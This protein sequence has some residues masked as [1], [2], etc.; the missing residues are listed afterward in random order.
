MGASAPLWF[1]HLTARI[2]DL[3]SRNIGS[4]PIGTDVY[5][6]SAFYFIYIGMKTINIAYVKLDSKLEHH[7][8]HA[9]IALSFNKNRKE[10]I[11]SDVCK[12]TI[13]KI[14]W[15]TPQLVSKFFPEYS[16]RISG[17]EELRIESKSEV[18]EAG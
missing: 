9:S 2:L 7:L 4:N 8:L 14:F 10:L 11:L 18:C 16:T 15:A 17:L 1:H 3:Q 12:D 6:T 5:Y 13:Y